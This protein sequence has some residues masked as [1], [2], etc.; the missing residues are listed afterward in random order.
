MTA[1]AAARKGI[2]VAVCGE[3][4]GRPEAAACLLG[5]GIRDLSMNPTSIPSVKAVL[6]EHSEKE[7]KELANSVLKGSTTQ[8]THKYLDAWRKKR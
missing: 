1:D 8:E 6:C 7:M 4:A 3:M 5:M 2:N